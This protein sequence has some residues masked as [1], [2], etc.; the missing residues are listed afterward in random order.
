MAMSYSLSSEPSLGEP[1]VSVPGQ[2]PSETPRSQ[3]VGWGPCVRM[4]AR[5]VQMSKLKLRERMGSGAQDLT[6]R[7]AE[8]ELESKTLQTGASPPSTSPHPN[9]GCLG[10]VQMK[11]FRRH[12]CFLNSFLVSEG[13]R[14][15]SQSGMSLVG[16]RRGPGAPGLWEEWA[17][18]QA[19]E[20]TRA[21]KEELHVG[22]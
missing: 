12:I 21:P 13:R 9:H 4:I 6:A 20:G 14:E 17:E 8:L 22:W 3:N 2:G 10:W 18:S 19:R 5:T 7:E 11:V 1:T 16:V 15:P